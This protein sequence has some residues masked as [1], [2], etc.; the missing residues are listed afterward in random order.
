MWLYNIQN[1]LLPA[2]CLLCDAPSGLVANLCDACASEFPSNSSACPRCALPLPKTIVCPACQRRPPAYVH[3]YCPFRYASPVNNLIHLMKFKR[4]LA[5]AHTLGCLL[6]HHLTRTLREYPECIIPVPLHGSRLRE[7]GY[8]QAT[9]L[10]RP[11]AK[12][13]GVPIFPRAVQR[14][15][16]TAPQV[17]L[18]GREKRRRNVRGAFQ[19]L[20]SIGNLKHVAIVDDVITTTSTVAELAKVL[21]SAG[22]QRVDVWSCARA[23]SH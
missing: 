6:A 16:A 23:E 12:Q 18:S 1:S 21:R 3:T 11:V 19:V 9:E 22:V 5:A 17:E 7:R 2:V 14:I 15:R 20:G 13:L 10:V 4:K 8:N